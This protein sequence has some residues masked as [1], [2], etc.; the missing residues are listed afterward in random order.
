MEKEYTKFKSSLQKCSILFLEQ[1]LTMDNTSILNWTDIKNNKWFMTS[2]G[3]KPPNWYLWI[4]KNEETIERTFLSNYD[5]TWVIKG[6]KFIHPSA[7]ITYNGRGKKEFSI[8]CYYDSSTN[9]SIIGKIYQRNLTT[10]EITIHHYRPKFNPRYPDRIYFEK[11]LGCELNQQ[12]RLRT[13]LWCTSTHFIEDLLIIEQSGQFCRDENRERYLIIDVNYI[14]QLTYKNHVY[15][16]NVEY[17]KMHNQLAVKRPPLTHAKD[18]IKYIE[19]STAQNDLMKIRRSNEDSCQFEFYT[20][21]SLINQGTMNSNITCG[22]I[23]VGD[24]A[25]YSEFTTN[26]E[27]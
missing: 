27:L 22:F 13:N 4:K 10:K 17:W 7:Y 15:N 20:D 26:I 3:R 23:Q 16:T 6:D 24:R 12:N 18:I 19:R 14:Y 5:R 2:T 8:V 9:N 21:G 11:C 1:I 25:P